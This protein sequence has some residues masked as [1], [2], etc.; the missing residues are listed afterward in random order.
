MGAP[1]LP[2]AGGICRAF[3]AR[4]E[5]WGEKGAS[6][7][8]RP[9][10]EARAGFLFGCAERQAARANNSS[11]NNNPP[12]RSRARQG[13]LR[14]SYCL[15]TCQE[16][17]SQQSHRV[18]APYRRLPSSSLPSP[19]KGHGKPPGE[20]KVLEGDGLLQTAAAKSGAAPGFGR[21]RDVGGRTPTVAVGTGF[22]TWE[23]FLHF[24]KK[25][26]LVGGCR[27]ETEGLR[28]APPPG[29]CS[30][31]FHLCHQ[32]SAAEPRRIRETRGADT[33]THT[34]L[35]FSCL[36]GSPRISRSYRPNC[37]LSALRNT[38]GGPG[39]RTPPAWPF[40]TLSGRPASHSLL[41]LSRSSHP[42]LGLLDFLCRGR[43]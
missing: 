2:G 15:D 10:P 22:K 17:G 12:S 24:E 23:K 31:F 34:G 9:A 19:R 36:Q 21:R 3:R 7:G 38:P 39:R 33:R 43:D 42:Q 29:G 40:H 13:V 28:P 16:L 18:P 37:H 41:S 20:G 1:W 6:G 25:G 35:Q 11:Y 32:V 5:R 27:G 26:P 14:P 8:P 30:C 4:R